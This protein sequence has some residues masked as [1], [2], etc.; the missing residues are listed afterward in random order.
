MKVKKPPLDDPAQSARFVETAK[1]LDADKGGAAFGQ[2][3]KKVV[4]KKKHPQKIHS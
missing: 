1:G 2:A 3:I 4:P